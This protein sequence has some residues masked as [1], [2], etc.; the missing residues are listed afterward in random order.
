MD[1]KCTFF[2]K[3]KTV[4]VEHPKK[5]VIDNLLHYSKSIEIITNPFGNS[6]IISNN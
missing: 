5:T 1:S 6:F 3:I 2:R 4:K